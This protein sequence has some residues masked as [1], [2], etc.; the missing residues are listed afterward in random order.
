MKQLIKKPLLM[1]VGLLVLALSTSASAVILSFNPASQNAVAGDTVSLDLVIS[2]LGTD[3]IGDF[4][5]DIAFDT[6]ALSFT[7]YSLGSGLGDLGLFEADDFSLGDLGGGLIGLTEVSYLSVLDLGLA[8]PGASLTLATLDFY[9]DTLAL[10]SSTTVSVD[11][12]YAI[13][14]GVGDPLN[15]SALNDGVISNPRAVPEPS[16]LALFSLGLIGF[17]VFRKTK[18]K[19]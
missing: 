1:I 12:I 15:D 4:D 5:L 11:T 10:G 13:G 19:V 2:D 6:S 16:V 14:D 8:Q 9:V 3:L 7:G 18:K 17:G